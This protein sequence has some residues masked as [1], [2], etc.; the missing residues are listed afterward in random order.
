[1]LLDGRQIPDQ[2]ASNNV[3]LLNSSKFNKLMDQADA[4]SGDARASAYGRLDIQMM[5]EAAPW[6][7][8]INNTNRIFL[9]DRISNFT[10]NVANTYVALN[11]LNIK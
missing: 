1:M 8:Y 9:S 4:L 3:A 11:A 10:Y 7:P 2:G 6:A 5:K